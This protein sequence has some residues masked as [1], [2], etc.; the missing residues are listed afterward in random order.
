MAD[1]RVKRPELRQV[2]TDVSPVSGI[3]APVVWRVM[4]GMS[5][6]SGILAPAVVWRVVTGM[7]PVS[8]ILA[9]VVWR[10]MTGLSP[11]SGILARVKEGAETMGG[12]IQA[13]AGGVGPKAAG[14]SRKGQYRAARPR[15]K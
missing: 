2:T 8:G 9:P 11:V 14:E 4:T 1:D 7:S 13:R 10:V 5:P 15:G 6:V 12:I 3:L